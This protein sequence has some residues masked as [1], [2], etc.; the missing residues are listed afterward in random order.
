MSDIYQLR[1]PDYVVQTAKE[2]AD[3]D[4]NSIEDALIHMLNQAASG[5]L[6]EWLPDDS[7][8]ALAD[9]KLTDEQQE[10]FSELLARNREDLLTDEDRARFNEVMKMYRR[11]MLVKAEALR[12]AIQRGLRPRLDA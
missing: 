11:G 4:Q 6:I 3:A 7:V 5:P 2:L 10:E 8:L 12:V 1:P 9:M